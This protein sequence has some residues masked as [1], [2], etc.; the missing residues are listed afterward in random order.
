MTPALSDDASLSGL[1]LSD[2]TIGA[3][4]PATTAYAAAAAHDV[5]EITVTATVSDAAASHAIE[6]GGVADADATVALAVG[7]NTIAVVVTAA[8]GQ[9][10]RTY[11]V[12]VTRAAAPLTAVFEEAPA[13]HDGSAPFTLRVAFSEPI[14]TGYVVVRD[15]A[16]EVTGGAV[17]GAWRVQRRSDLWGIRIQPDGDGDVTVALPAGRA[18]GT[19][20]AVCTGDGT[21]LSNR[22][23][24][25]IPGPAVPGPIAVNSPATGAPA[26]AGTA[27][28]GETLTASTSGIADADGLANASFAHQWITHDGGADTDIAGATAAAYSPVAADAG[29]TV[30]VRVTFTDDAGHHESLTSA[31]TAAV[32]PAPSDD[33]TLSSLALSDVDFGAF[34]AATADY[35]AAVAHDVT[36]TTV[37]A[38]VNHAAASHTVQLDGTTDADGTVDLAAGANTI[39]VT[40]TAED[41]AT[42]RTYTVTVTRAAPPAAGD[43][44]EVPEGLTGEFTGDGEVQLDWDDTE[45]ATGYVARFWKL[46]EWVDLPTDE[47]AISF[48]GSAAT[49]T[50]LPRYGIYYFAVRAA[51]TAGQSDWTHWLTLIHPDG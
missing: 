28:V 4:D 26:I 43:P 13:S 25:T 19:A 50:G 1:E 24:A 34:D 51:N 42:T 11:T 7:P 40:V 15:H 31:A 20:G 16:L 49:V 2:V 29:R 38:T 12:T 18:C 6:L 45:G 5:T 39:T 35:T 10:T 41:G 27:R 14:A 8:D 30:R 47:I 17:T 23:E 33:A 9:A 32:A 3:F 48:D 46:T 36:Q 22:P 44:P 21:T 37:T